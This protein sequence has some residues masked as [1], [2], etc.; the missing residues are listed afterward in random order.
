MHSNQDLLHK[1]FQKIINRK[2]FVIIKRPLQLSKCLLVT[3]LL[4]HGHNSFS[5]PCYTDRGTCT[6][7]WSLATLPSQLKRGKFFLSKIFSS[8]HALPQE[9][10]IKPSSQ[11]APWLWSTPW[12]RLLA[13]VMF[14]YP[15][16]DRQA[17]CTPSPPLPFLPPMHMAF[18][19]SARQLTQNHA[20]K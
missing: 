11:C 13:A 10:W 4:D 15:S 3:Y 8:P 6:F 16:Q 17:S 2:T 19:T 14:S 12:S 9:E 1:L 20:W 7:P 5:D 18:Q